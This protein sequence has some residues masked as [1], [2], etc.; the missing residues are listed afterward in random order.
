MSQMYRNVKSNAVVRRGVPYKG[1]EVIYVGQRRTLIDPAKFERD[2]V[3][4]GQGAYNALPVLERIVSPAPGGNQSTVYVP[5]PAIAQPSAFKPQPKYD[6][7]RAE[8]W[9][10]EVRKLPCQNCGA[11]P[12]SESSHAN[13]SRA[14]KGKG[15][16]ASNI[17]AALCHACH[18]ALD[19]GSEAT[20]ME[21][22]NTWLWAFFKTTEALAVNGAIKIVNAE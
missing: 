5:K 1:Q 15:I 18:A 14:G 19:Q 10:R 16:K 12:R 21:R 20:R 4:I 13:W 9:E 22:E 2:Y 7:Y 17:T 3:S 6:Y 8:D 11:P